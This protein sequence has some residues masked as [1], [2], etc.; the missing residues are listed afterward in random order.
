MAS[1][2]TDD[3]DRPG[4]D[5]A[6]GADATEGGEEDMT[7]TMSGQHGMMGETLEFHASSIRRRNQGLAGKQRGLRSRVISTM[8]EGG[9]ETAEGAI[10]NYEEEVKL[11]RQLGEES[12]LERGRRMKDLSNAFKRDLETIPAVR[13]QLDALQNRAAAIVSGLESSSV[14]RPQAGGDEDPALT[15]SAESCNQ[16]LQ[17]SISLLVQMGDVA[18]FYDHPLIRNPCLALPALETAVQ[19]VWRE[20]GALGPAPRVGILGWLGHDHV[21]PRGLN[22][23]KVNRLVCVEGVVNRCTAVQPK[24]CRAV[25]VSEIQGGQAF[26]GQEE[27]LDGGDGQER[28]VYVRAFYDV[29]NLDKDIRDTQ[30]PPER[31]PTGVRVNRQE[32]GYSYFK[33]VQRFLVQEA[34]ETAPTGQLP[35]YVEV[36]VEEDLC[37]KVK[38]GDRVRVWGVYRPG[39]GTINGTSSGL[40]KPFLIA[41]NLQILTVA[42][43][44]TLMRNLPSDLENL[45]MFSRRPDLLSVLTRSFAPSICGHELVKRGLLLQLAGGVE[46]VSSAHR[47]RG[48]I[49]VLLV[50][51]PSAGKSQLLR[52]VLNLIPG[53]VSATGRGSSGVGLTAA[54]VTDAETGERRVEGGAMVMADRSLVCIDEFDKMLAGDRVAI[55]E[56]ME[57]Q[58][59]T[60]AKAGIHT[61]LNA[62]CSVLAAANP[63]YGCW[64]DDM[65]YKQQ[66]TFED[67]LMSRFDLIFIVRD[68]ATTAEDERLATAVLRNV[69]EKAK[70]VCS[71]GLE[72]RAA[73]NF[74]VQPHRDMAQESAER[75]EDEEEGATKVF[76]Q[77]NEMAYLDKAGRE[78][79]VLTT[80][81][82]K[83]YIQYVRRCRYELE[84]EEDAAPALPAGFDETKGDAKG[85]QLSDDA[86]QAIIKFYSDIRDR[87][88]GRGVGTGAKE[89]EKAG[90]NG[91]AM[92]RPVTARS[93]EAVVR[94]ATAHAKLKMQRWVTPDDVRVAKGMMLYTLFGEEPEDEEEDSDLDS[95]EDESEDDEEFVA[96]RGLRRASKRADAGG[97]DA[98]QK[99]ASRTRSKRKDSIHQWIISS[100]QASEDGSGVEVSQLFA[101][102]AEKAKAAGMTGFSEEELRQEL[103]ELDSR[104]SAP[105][106]F[107]GS[108]VYEC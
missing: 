95:D 75:A 72:R 70:P 45:R 35:R 53:S 6:V 64:A 11:Q 12:N 50:G 101:L 76:C 47:I 106:L 103:V 84:D 27:A 82:L 85:P 90:F 29:S 46:R 74:Q 17:L 97:E 15:G 49:H 58:T 94:L 32:L 31:D 2:V 19:E 98:T 67:S 99:R 39:M 105:L 13:Q 73:G 26:P 23:V 79:E 54:I 48:D 40:V 86:A 52:F 80:D 5:G 77:R 107:H 24:L 92:L 102:V 93:L 51:D 42:A 28:Q 41:N 44:A 60:V 34:P 57:Q 104:D 33:N 65:D 55:H 22:S 4:G 1:Y 68:S 10:V 66:L 88:F 81:F 78:H 8:S 59:V 87:C 89:S 108:R 3:F 37:D 62:R 16:R 18:S 14:A 71:G 63:L 69:T 56:V 61:T 9:L 91:G 96:P 38:C 83:K 30:P 43:R 25:Y 21:T 36:L 20:R 7:G 100:L